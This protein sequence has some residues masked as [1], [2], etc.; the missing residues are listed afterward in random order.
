M[1]HKEKHLAT[2]PIVV[3]IPIA[4]VRMAQTLTPQEL[5]RLKKAVDERGIDPGDMVN[6]S[7]VWRDL[8]GDPKTELLRGHT[9]AT[10][11]SL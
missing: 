6:V 1:T 11:H 10:G 5:L 8:R 3:M 9:V 7:A 2:A 4:W